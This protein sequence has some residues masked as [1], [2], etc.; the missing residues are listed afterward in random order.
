MNQTNQL[1]RRDGSANTNGTSA[2]AAVPQTISG[3][4]GVRETA[5]T[6]AFSCLACLIFG[7][8]VG[9]FF[10]KQRAAALQKKE[11]G[12]YGVSAYEYPCFVLR[13]S[14]NS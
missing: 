6:V 7:L 1:F 8:L 12:K 4:L 3:P 9:F 11:R 5:I 2:S 13:I 10:Q 14:F